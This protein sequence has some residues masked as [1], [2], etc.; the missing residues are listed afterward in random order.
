MPIARKCLPTRA[1]NGLLNAL[2]AVD[3]T[4]SYKLEPTPTEALLLGRERLKQQGNLGQVS[5]KQIEEWMALHGMSFPDQPP[6]QRCPH[7]GQVIR[8]KKS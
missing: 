8:R 2:R 4:R 1:Y 5:I 3:N 7:C 6:V